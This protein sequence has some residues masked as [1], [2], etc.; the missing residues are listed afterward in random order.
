MSRWKEFKDY[1]KS[2]YPKPDKY[3]YI[4]GLNGD[5]WG[6]ESSVGVARFIDGKWW[7]KK[8]INLRGLKGH[9]CS[10]V[11]GWAKI[12]K[13]FVEKDGEYM[14]S[15]K[16]IPQGTLFYSDGCRMDSVCVK[17]KDF[18]EDNGCSFN[19]V[20][21]RSGEPQHF[22]KNDIVIIAGARIVTDN[23]VGEMTYLN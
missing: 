23:E 4:Y 18:D 21:I 16:D 7:C 11:F 12:G 6:M 15:F 1:D 19:A 22:N 9:Y 5:R 10:P 13:N 14:N 3:Y 8:E 17:I 2:T 20:D